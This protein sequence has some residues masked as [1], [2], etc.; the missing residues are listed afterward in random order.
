VPAGKQKIASAKD[1]VDVVMSQL[2]DLTKEV[3]KVVC[4]DSNS[5][6]VDI[7]EAASGTVNRAMPIVEKLFTVFC[8]SLRYRLSVCAIIHLGIRNQARKTEILPESQAKPEMLFRSK[9]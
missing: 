9:F 4:L 3:F 5:R 2:R 7:T 1:V 6:I 8:K